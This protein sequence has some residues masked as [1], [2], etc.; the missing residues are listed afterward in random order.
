MKVLFL[1]LAFISFSMLNAQETNTKPGAFVRVYDLEGTK[2]AKG[3]IISLNDSTIVTGPEGNTDTVNRNRI[4]S[5]K[6]KRSAG[7]NVLMGAAIGTGTGA[8]LGIASGG[9]NSWWGQGEGAGGFGLFFGAVGAG[10]GAITIIF[11]KSNTFVI[12]GDLSKWKTF[13][14]A[15]LEE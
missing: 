13:K 10:I 14:E 5:I 2:I 8:I 6:T 15:M 12:E 3:K 7:N 1:T 9:E 11:K 4:G